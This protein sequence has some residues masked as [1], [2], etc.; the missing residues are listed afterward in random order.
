MKPFPLFQ[1]HPAFRACPSCRRPMVTAT[2]VT[3]ASMSG[4][5]Q[6]MGVTCYCVSC[7]RRY[8][9]ASRL[10]TTV[11]AWMGPLGRRLWGLTTSFE[12]TLKPEE[13]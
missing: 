6:R 9:A 8:R 4:P 7:N 5:L 13:F 11:V 3:K 1:F 10:P 12:P 2:L